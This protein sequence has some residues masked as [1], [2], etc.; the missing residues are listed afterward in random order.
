[1]LLVHTF[2][3]M[4]AQRESWAKQAAQ[5]GLV[6][7]MGYLHE[8]H[9]SLVRQAQRENDKVVVTIFVNPLQFGPKEDLSRY[10]RDL[11][12]DITFLEKEGVDLIFNPSAGE[13]YPAGFDTGI[14]VGGVSSQLEGQIRPGHFRGVT[15]VVAKLF[16]LVGAQKAYFGQKDAQQILV[17]KKMVRD[18]N[19]PIEVIVCPTLREEDGLAMS[20]RNIYLSAEDRR[21]AP[22]IFRALKQA[23]KYWKDYPARR[24]GPELKRIMEETLAEISRGRPDYT[25]AA[26]PVTLQE[27]EG[28]IPPGKGVL[29]SLA[30]RFENTRL[31]DN[32]LLEG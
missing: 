32:F 30:V 9:L 17:I 24:N 14:E 8:G 20:S 18:L 12:R 6:P 29:L 11:A 19:F 27:Y 15:T 13:M 25:S 5:V 28:L 21:A 1:M 23:A 4:V 7:T 26:D 2:A 16:H 3:E 10:P 22:L 31:I